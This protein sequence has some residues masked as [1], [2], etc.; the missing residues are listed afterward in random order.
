[1]KTDNDLVCHTDVTM[2]NQHFERAIQDVNN[3]EKHF[4]SAINHLTK[5]IN[6]KEDEYKSIKDENA[7]LRER[8]QHIN[9]FI[10][11]AI[12][13]CILLYLLGFTSG[14]YVCS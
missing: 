1:M 4:T 6:E 8:Q 11:V 10:T 14:W 2:D 5:A 7:M 12:V 3:M 13:V 9:E